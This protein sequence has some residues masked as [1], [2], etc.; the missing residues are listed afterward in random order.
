M[1]LRRFKL[2]VLSIFVP[3]I[4]AFIGA[5]SSYWFN[6]RD[7]LDAIALTYLV[8]AYIAGS[9]AFKQISFSSKAALYVAESF[10]SASIEP[11]ARDSILDAYLYAQAINTTSRFGS[12]EKV[13]SLTNIG[14]TITSYILDNE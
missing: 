7:N 10:A 6:M 1:E 14:D 13:R 11:E 3:M 5:Q 2:L 4:V 9:L 12:L 8:V